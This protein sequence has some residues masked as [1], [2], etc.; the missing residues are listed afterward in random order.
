MADN[1]AI[2]AGSGT[3]VATDDVSGVHYQKVKLVASADD[4]SAALS[5]A[6]DAAHTSGDHGIMALG[7]RNDANAALSGTDL[8]YTPIAVDSAGNPQVD[9]VAALPAGT[10]AIGKLAANSG[11]DIGD[12]DVTSV[13][14]GSGATN[15]G[16]AED[17]VHASGDVGVLAL[18]VRQAANAPLSGTDGDYEPLQTD[19]NGH[20][21]VNVI[22]AL[23]AGTNAIGK[24]AANS[25][26]DVGDVDVT[27]VIPGSG[28]TNLGKAEDAIHASGDVG[29]MALGVANEANTVLAANGDYIPLAVD[30][31]GNLR[32]VGNRDHDA[33][34]AG[35]VVGVGGRTIAHGANPTAVAAADRSVWY[36]NRAGI[37]FVLGGHPNVVTL[38]AAYTTAQTDAAIVT[39]ATGLKIVLTEIGAY[40]DNANTVDV[41]VRVGFGATTTPTTTGVVLTHPG[42]AAGSGT[43][44]GNGSGILGAGADGEDLRITSEVPT[45]GSLRILV[46]Y[47]TIES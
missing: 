7:V 46:S 9:I 14:P 26:V 15:L 43:V 47:F 11:V 35:E 5:R 45:G 16:K 25:G 32:I 4:S 24:L 41:G 42:I 21:K 8:D 3:T 39:V 2:T 40:C 18:G 20:L 23:P 28:A 31:E 33:V 6:E 44:R 13:I 29:V 38:E 27:S 12:V 30:T 36:F 10:N 17:A 19:A 1:I 22:D 37:P 34:D